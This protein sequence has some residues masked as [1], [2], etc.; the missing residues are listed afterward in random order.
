MTPALSRLIPNFVEGPLFPQLICP[1]NQ[2]VYGSMAH[3]QLSQLHFSQLLKSE[4]L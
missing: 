3:L 1:K 4:T 2:N